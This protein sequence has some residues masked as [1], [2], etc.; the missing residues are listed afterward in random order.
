MLACVLLRPSFN[1]NFQYLHCESIQASSPVMSRPAEST[2]GLLSIPSLR[3]EMCRL[4][5]ILS[6]F[7]V[8]LLVCI[9]SDV[10]S[11]AVL[12][13]LHFFFLFLICLCV[14]ACMIAFIDVLNQSPSSW[15]YLFGICAS[16]TFLFSSTW[17]CEFFCCCF[18]FI[19]FIYFN[20]IFLCC[21]H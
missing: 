2:G 18:L 19:Y 7:G 9:K 6:S 4:Q 13:F 10:G 12:V 3:L 11:M 20:F 5:R 17:P 16:R 15:R 21:G 1:F 8:Y 14:R